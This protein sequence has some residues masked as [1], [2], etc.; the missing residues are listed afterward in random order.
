MIFKDSKASDR[1]SKK[2]GHSVVQ[3]PR[4][5][6]RSEGGYLLVFATIIGFLLVANYLLGQAPS[7]SEP[8]QLSYMTEP[9]G[10]EVSPAD[11]LAKL[12]AGEFKTYTGG[13]ETLDLGYMREGV[14][15]HMTFRNESL[16]KAERFVLQLRHTYINGSFSPLKMNTSETSSKSFSIEST[17]EFTDKLLPRSQGL[18]DIRHVSFPVVVAPTGEFH[19]LIRLKAHVMSVPF[20]L[21]AENDF[22]S[23][24]VRE[25]VVTASLFGGLMLLAVYNAMVG[26]ARR[27]HEFIFYGGYVASIS[28]M[29]VAINGSGHMFIWP[30]MLWLHYNSANLLINLCCMTY[31]AFT[32]ALFR[33]D[34]L[35]GIERKIWIGMF[36]VCAIGL[37]LQLVEGGFFASIEANMIVLATLCASLVRAWRARPVYG[38]IANLFLLSEGMLFLG[39]V[40]YCVKMFG[41]LPSTPFTINIVTLAATLEG[42]LLSFVLSEKMRRTMN[43]R[44]IA[45]EQLAEA[46]QHLEASVRDRTL[47]LAARYTSH[48]VLNPVFAIRLKAE[49]IRDEVLIQVARKNSENSAL[50]QQVLTKVNEIF[51]LIDSIIHTIRAIKTLAGDGNREDAV[52]V[53]VRSAF[54]DAL[55]MLEAK[56]VQVNCK[57]DFD[58]QGQQHVLARRSDVVQ[59]LMNLVSNSMDAVSSEQEKWICIGSR[60]VKT[61]TDN[62]ESV[63]V[64]IDVIDSGAGPRADVRDRLFDAEVTTKDAGGGMGLGLAFCQKLVRRNNGEIAFDAASARTR[65]YFRLP[66]AE[67]LLLPSSDR[68]A[69]RA[70]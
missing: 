54:D 55:R 6:G 34:P 17:K 45:M 1:D 62:K 31:L 28:L 25:M 26:F 29:I 65:F 57:I 50:E 70:A 22:L 33:H 24:I 15:V 4:V 18:N 44:E 67:Q 58:F 23:S 19:A 12:N 64:E 10:R 42:I 38:R 52:R 7:K 14:W 66:A 59:V 63:W 37:I 61:V 3:S 46:Q 21:L 13:T 60:V 43:E 36:S 20:L 30:D 56:A 11:A 40:V 2:F 9:L 68:G 47:A 49:R 8:V 51:K 27:E 16:S 35:K 32:L 48:E 5:A 39:A 53:D 69:R 41:W